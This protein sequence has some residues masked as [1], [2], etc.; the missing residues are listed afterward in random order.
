[1]ADRKSSSHCIPGAYERTV[2]DPG[3]PDAPNKLD[4]VAVGLARLHVADLL[5]P[6]GFEP[7]ADAIRSLLSRRRLRPRDNVPVGSSRI[8]AALTELGEIKPRRIFGDWQ[9]ANYDGAGLIGSLLTRSGPLPR[10]EVSTSDI[11][12]LRKLDLRPTF[13]AI[14]REILEAIIRGDPNE[15][16]NVAQRSRRSEDR[17]ISTDPSGS[18]LVHVGERIHVR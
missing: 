2:V 14:E 13:V 15:I 8:G 12:T 10:A 17:A 4:E 5:E 11:Q 1:M 18:W 9:G 7:L 6:L 16:R 3:D